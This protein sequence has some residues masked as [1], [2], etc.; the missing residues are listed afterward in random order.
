MQEVVA[1]DDIRTIAR[2]AGQ[3]PTA[4]PFIQGIGLYLSSS[5]LCVD[6]VFVSLQTLHPAFRARTYLWKK[7]T[8]DVRIVEWPHGLTNRPGYYDSPDFNVHTSRAEFRVRNLPEVRGHR[9]ELYGRLRNEGYTDYLM[10]PLIFVDGTVN[11]LSIATKL[12]GGFPEEGLLRFR[13]LIDVFTV[14]IER[15]SALETV[16][17]TLGTYLGREASREVMRG[18][19]HAGHGEMIHAGMLF[20]DIHGFTRH[21]SCLGPS[22]T[23]QLLNSYF[24]C[25]VAPIEAMGGHVLK[26]IGDAILAYFPMSAGQ[27]D[28]DPVGAVRAIRERLADLN[29][30]RYAKGESPVRLGVGLHFS[31]VLFGNVGSSERL[32]FT[33]I[34]EAVNVTARCAEETRG[35]EFDYVATGAFVARFG[36]DHFLPI[37]THQLRGVAEPVALFALAKDAGGGAVPTAA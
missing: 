23:V 18:R 4:Q 1:H 20:G 15:Y 8:R 24:D 32:D 10:V 30:A 3:L 2:L 34:G 11:T 17:V 19:I 12:P 9:C 37:G 33:I 29:Q 28:P 22:G 5:A 25:L 35:L 27:P 16:S 7:Q 14:A 21:A 26:F 31:E 13:E 36:A 6:R